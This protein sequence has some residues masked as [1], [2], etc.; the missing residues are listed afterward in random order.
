MINHDRWHTTCNNHPIIPPV[1]API[2]PVQLP[3]PPAHPV[4][5][6]TQTI[7]PAPMP[8]LKWLHFEPE[9]AGNPDEDVEEHLLRTSNWIDTHV[10]KEGVKIKQF[11][12]TLVGEARLWYELLRPITL[13]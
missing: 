6:P 10:F 3:A 7:Q 5:P 4:V 2:P 8:Q 11:C 12:L 1:V 9:F 13:D